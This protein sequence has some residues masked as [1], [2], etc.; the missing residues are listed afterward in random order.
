MTQRLV[1]DTGR[2][3]FY[4]PFYGE[5][6]NVVVEEGFADGHVDMHGGM[7]FEQSLVDETVAEPMLLVQTTPNPS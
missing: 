1:G 4:F 5:F 6:G 3:Q 7:L 2:Q